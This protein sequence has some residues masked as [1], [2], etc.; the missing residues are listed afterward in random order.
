M[1]GFDLVVPASG[2]R[3]SRGRHL[4]GFTLVELL[5]VIAIIGVL[6]ALLLPAVQAARESARRT[7]CTN[8]LKQLALGCH[9]Y[10]DTHNALPYAYQQN[11][12]HLARLLPYIE[13][14][15]LHDRV[16]YSLP[17]TDPSNAFVSM[18]NVSGFVCP[19]DPNM[20]PPG[21]GGT[22]NYYANMGS[23]IV[24]SAPATAS[25]G[26]NFGMADQ[27]G[28]FSASVAVRFA[29]ILDGTSNTALMS[30]R[31]R[32][33]GSNGISTPLSDTY[34]PGTYPATADQAMADCMAVNT[35]DLSKQGF[36][37]VGVPW[38]RP[39]HSTTAYF[40]VLPPNHR[41]CMF[42]PQR[43]ATSAGSRHPG[44]VMVGMADGGVRFV[45]RT[46]NVTTWRAVGS[47]DGGE[48]NHGF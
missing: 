15:A 12:S 9:N 31:P 35:A 14:S 25:G 13:Q 28:A 36:S 32:G 47:R 7:Q 22:N 48:V 10:H 42:P 2:H 27:N 3:R 45:S 11:I 29:D 26:V 30:E 18:A 24:N 20:L 4:S 1:L 33:D 19:S 17:F 21:L 40:H 5:V 23:N 38:L 46:I 39:Y 41:S 37:N 43:I 44:G 8:N 16:N 34:Q 6:V